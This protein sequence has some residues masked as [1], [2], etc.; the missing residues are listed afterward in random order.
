[1]RGSLL[2]RFALCAAAATTTAAGEEPA[3]LPAHAAGS[4]QIH[5]FAFMVQLDVQDFPHLFA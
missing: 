5:P 3:E 1:M 2:L 4:L